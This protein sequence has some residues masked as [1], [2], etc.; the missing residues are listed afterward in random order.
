MEGIL[1]NPALFDNDIFDHNAIKECWS[2]FCKGN[3]SV[4]N[5]LE[6]LIE[7]GLLTSNSNL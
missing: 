5:D 2:I 6:K 4:A 1:N 3:L 7:M